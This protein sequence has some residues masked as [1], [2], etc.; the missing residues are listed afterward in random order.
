M[1]CPNC[2]VDCYE[3]LSVINDIE[4]YVVIGNRRIKRKE[5]KITT[6]YIASYICKECRIGW[7]EEM[8]DHDYCQ[9]VRD[10]GNIYLQ[11]SKCKDRKIFE[12]YD[13]S[14]LTIL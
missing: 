3:E 13:P 4:E 2:G 8:C 14:L 6:K 5:P 12:D 10:S 7:A 9:I 1:K 11:C